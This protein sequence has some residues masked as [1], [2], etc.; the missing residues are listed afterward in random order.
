MTLMGKATE[1][2][3]D[4]VA[5]VVLGPHF[6]AQGEGDEPKKVSSVS[7]RCVFPCPFDALT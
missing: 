1:K 4:E 6:H 7:L 5:R 2:G 3:L